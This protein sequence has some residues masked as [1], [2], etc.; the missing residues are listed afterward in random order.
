MASRFPLALKQ[1]GVSN[2]PTLP[3]FVPH[4][5]ELHSDLCF[6][7][8]SLVALSGPRFSNSC[9]LAKSLDSPRSLAWLLASQNREKSC[10]Q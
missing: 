6:M 8:G 4:L 5:S 2:F 7:A 3:E 9:F 1:V 10:E